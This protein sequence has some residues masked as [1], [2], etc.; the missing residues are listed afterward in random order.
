MIEYFKP[1]N[2]LRN[3]NFETSLNEDF[4]FSGNF[5]IWRELD[6]GIDNNGINI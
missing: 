2:P 6:F 5:Q 1:L 4:D 3:I